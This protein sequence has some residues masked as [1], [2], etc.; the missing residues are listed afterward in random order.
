MIGYIVWTRR[1]YQRLQQDPDVEQQLQ[2]QPQPQQQQQPPPPAAA[3]DHQG[4]RAVPAAVRA[5]AAR[6]DAASSTPRPHNDNQF[7]HQ[8]GKPIEAS[9]SSIVP[10]PSSTASTWSLRPGTST[11]SITSLR[12]PFNNFATQRRKRFLSMSGA[13][14]FGLSGRGS[15]GNGGNGN[16]NNQEA[17][18]MQMISLNKN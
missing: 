14:N 9:D 13:S 2:P 12:D 1:F 8:G 5:K 6:T 10:P 18:E 17:I 4:Q 7:D 11:T 15:S 3:A 16:N